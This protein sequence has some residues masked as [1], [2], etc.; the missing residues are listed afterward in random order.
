MTRRRYCVA[1]SCCN[2]V[3]PKSS[4]NYLGTMH[5][6]PDRLRFPERYQEWVTFCQ[7]EP[8][9]KPSQSSY[10]CDA[11]FNSDKW[12]FFKNQVP[13]IPTRL[14]T[15]PPQIEDILTSLPLDN[16]LELFEENVMDTTLSLSPKKNG[17]PA[18]RTL[19]S[20][21]E[22]MDVDLMIAEQ[23]YPALELSLANIALVRIPPGWS[24]LFFDPE[25]ILFA[26]ISKQNSVI[27]RSVGFNARLGIESIFFCQNVTILI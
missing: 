2:A 22:E 18:D 6:F 24:L 7:R 8:G 1:P 9:W 21:G 27:T 4:T 25:L 17:L 15:A 5:K 16:T 20:I 26:E 11:H 13:T 12:I 10:I 3:K 23:V 14:T 19:D